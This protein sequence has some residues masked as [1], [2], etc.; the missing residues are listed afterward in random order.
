MTTHEGPSEPPRVHLPPPPISEAPPLDLNDPSLEP[1]EASN[2][3]AGAEVT[4]SHILIMHAGS[5]RKPPQVTRSQTEAEQLALQVLAQ[6]R[7][8]ADF[9][10]LAAKYSDEPGAAQRKGR[11]PPFTRPQMVKA[12]SDA[13]FQLE[14]GSI[15]DVVETE[16]GYHIIL[17]H[18]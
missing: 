3:D 12:F 7:D 8:G 10:E 13:A 14:P 15:S 4:V 6:A 9:G 5:K 16:F 1:V 17:R 11:L 18:D 2:P